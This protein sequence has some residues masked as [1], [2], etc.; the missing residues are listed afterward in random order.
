MRLWR[1]DW[2]W[3]QHH[4][5]PD[6]FIIGGLPGIGILIL[7]W[8]FLRGPTRKETPLSEAQSYHNLSTANSHFDLVLPSYQTRI[9]VEERALDSYHNVLFSIL[10]FWR[11]QSFTWP[12]YLTIVSHGFKRERLVA[13]HCNA[14][15]FPLSRVNFVGVD[16]HSHLDLGNSATMKGNRTALQQWAEDSHGKGDILAGKRKKRNPWGI[17]QRLFLTDVERK[18]SGIATRLTDDGGDVL[19]DGTKPW[20]ESSGCAPSAN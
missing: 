9:H 2:N 4:Y 6:L 20:E 13:G 15:A 3:L 18:A 7:T 14:I 5:L 1:K 12:T 19:D 11:T 10:Q 8:V 16:P 17:D